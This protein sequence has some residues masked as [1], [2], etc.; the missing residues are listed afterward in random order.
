[1]VWEQRWHPLREEWVLYTEH[2]GGRPWIGETKPPEAAAHPSYDPNC[3]LCPGNTRVHGENPAYTGVYWFT[4]DLPPFSGDAPPPSTSDELYRT[5]PVRGTSEVICYHPGHSKTFAGLEPAQ[6]TAVVRTWRD[7]YRAAAELPGV[8]YVLI[9]ENRG[10]LV[11]TS[12][13][14]PHCQLYAGNLVYGIAERERAAAAR[15]HAATGASLLQE[16]V[17]R[18]SASARVVASNAEFFACVPWFARYAY[19]VLVFPRRPVA[20]LADL[21][22]ARC[23]ALGETLLAVTRAY[24]KLWN[25]PMPY[26]MAIHQAPV[27]GNP[28]NV[29]YPFHIEFHP[30][31]RK[32]DTLKYLAGPEIGGGSMT[33]ESDPDKKAAELKE[34]AAC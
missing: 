18:E 15:Y 33:N 28:A 23:A 5:R 30:P 22:D 3:A 16:I 31:L 12:N 24:D 9:F 20:S 7:R 10:A 8:D 19:E 25:M 29:H 32:P 26:V 4:N 6:A 34:A 2:R 13:P 11:G 27:D 21:D 17:R 14:H 1:M